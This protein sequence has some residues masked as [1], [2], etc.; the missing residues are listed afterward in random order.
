LPDVAITTAI[1]RKLKYKALYK[2]DDLESLIYNFEETYPK[3]KQLL[4]AVEE[5]RTY[6]TNNHHQQ[7]PPDPE[8]WRAVSSRGADCHRV[9]GVNGQPSGEQAILQ[10]TADAMEQTRRAFTAP[11]SGENTEP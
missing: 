11:N 4:K 8:L 3:F 9:R 2:I 1:Y 5:F 6:I 7:P 10:E